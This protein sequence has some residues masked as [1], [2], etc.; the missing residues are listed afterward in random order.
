MRNL[1]AHRHR[2]WLLLIAGLLFFII[3]LVRVVNYSMLPGMVIE[4][5]PATF[6]FVTVVCAALALMVSLIVYCV[7]WVVTL[8]PAIKARRRS[9]ST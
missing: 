9:A 2:H 6:L 1:S 8:I 4:S 5:W 7:Q 3:V